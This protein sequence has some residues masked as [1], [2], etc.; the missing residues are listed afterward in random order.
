MPKKLRYGYTTGACA[1]AA[2]KAAVLQLLGPP[3]SS[4]EIPFPD[5]SR[6]A[7]KVNSSALSTEASALVSSASVIKDAGDDPDIT[8]GAEI[9]AQASFGAGIIIKGGVGV[10]TVTRPGLSVPVGEPAINPVPRRM[11]YAA[12]R[13]AI[14]DRSVEITISVP[15]GERLARKTLNPRLGIVGGISILGTTGIVKPL[16]ADAWTATIA[17][18]MDVAAATG[19][20]EIVLSAG[21]LSENAHRKRYHFP[22]PAYIMMGDYVGFSLQQAQRHNFKRVHL[23]AQW[24]KMLKI[25]MAA[26]CTHV[27]HGAID[28]EKTLQFLKTLDL[29]ACPQAESCKGSNPLKGFG[30]G[31]DR[32]ISINTARE[33]FEII[34]P[35]ANPAF[36]R[37]ICQAALKYV[38]M[39][40]P[41]TAVTTHLVSFGGDIIA[42]SD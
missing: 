36:F 18:S 3:P 23:C 24:A 41:E 2:A 35:K 42:G 21:R 9:A 20:E 31:T 32:N 12:V 4:V 11:I 14:S 22:E 6:V 29:S 30:L 34:N 15:E 38:K 26:P 7:F 25:A 5:G 28:M 33:L 1:A 8:H 19:C 40:A 16:S 13:E 37:Q 17:A 27:R 10:G 39:I